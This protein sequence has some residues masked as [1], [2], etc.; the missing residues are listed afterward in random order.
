MADVE[1]R[2]DQLAGWVLAWARGRALDAELR[3]EIAERL[4]TVRVCLRRRGR[5]AGTTFR[6][7][8]PA[9]EASVRE[10]LDALDRR[11]G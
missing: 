6:V 11:L 7:R 1:A 5:Q 9:T 8:G 4:E 3:V 2:V 10:A